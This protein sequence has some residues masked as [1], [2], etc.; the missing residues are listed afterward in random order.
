MTKLKPFREIIIEYAPHV[1]EDPHWDKSRDGGSLMLRAV[2]YI[3]S[4]NEVQLGDRELARE[5]LDLLLQE[6]IDPSVKSKLHSIPMSPL[7]LAEYKDSPEG[8]KLYDH[9]VNSSLES[10]SFESVAF[11]NKFTDWAK[12]VAGGALDK[13]GKTVASGVNL[14]GKLKSLKNNKDIDKA[15]KQAEDIVAKKQ[16]EDEA[17]MTDKEKAEKSTTIE[18]QKE[19]LKLI[20][21][22]LVEKNKRLAM[23]IAAQACREGNPNSSWLIKA[24]NALVNT[25]GVEES[26]RDLCIEFLLDPKFGKLLSD[27]IGKHRA[28]GLGPDKEEALKQMKVIAYW[29]EK[30]LDID[31]LRTSGRWKSLGGMNKVVKGL[32]N[33]TGDVVNPK[34]QELSG[35]ELLCKEFNKKAISSVDL[36]SYLSQKVFSGDEEKSKKFF[37]D[38][39]AELT[40][41]LNKNFKKTMEDDNLLDLFDLEIKKLVEK[42]SKS[43][44]LT[45]D[46]E[47]ALQALVGLGL[48]EKSMVSKIKKLGDLPAS[49]LVLA[50]LKSSGGK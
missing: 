50:I 1:I 19:A 14:V 31:Q 47:L 37:N 28:G 48:D 34:D 22:T 7:E 11:E 27:S 12:K 20:N 42:K 3:L 10:F 41:I 45:E 29:L 38:H 17:N 24:T 13:I 8:N 40:T 36:I 5:V 30:D 35:K 33:S 2:I 49:D 32:Q 39:R 4:N 21:Q 16:A 26:G 43:S 9:M 46:Q 18:K 25:L 15:V 6:G 44:S 23:Q